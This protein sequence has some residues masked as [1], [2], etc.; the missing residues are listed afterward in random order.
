MRGLLQPVRKSL[1]RP[2]YPP[3]I[4]SISNNRELQPDFEAVYMLMPTTQNIGRVIKDFTNPKQ[5]A[6]GHLFFIEGERVPARRPLTIW[7]LILLREPWPL[8]PP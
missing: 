8:R 7:L 4:E 2:S 1:T 6:A 5:Y 3:V